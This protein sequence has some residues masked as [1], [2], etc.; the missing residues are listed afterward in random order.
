MD[1]K[2]GAL[3]TLITALS[4]VTF[5]GLKIALGFESSMNAAIENDHLRVSVIILGILSLVAASCAVVFCALTTI[6]KGRN[7]SGTVAL[8][9]CH[10]SEEIGGMDAEREKLIQTLST[11]SHKDILFEFADQLANLGLIVE[12]KIKYFKIATLAFI[13]QLLFAIIGGV[14]SLISCI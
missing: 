10:R 9:P 1:G 4:A 11:L 6:G 5:F 12:Q 8:F 7:T 14:I 13:I 2:T 3:I